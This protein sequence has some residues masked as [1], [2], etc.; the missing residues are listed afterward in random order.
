MPGILSEFLLFQV[1]FSFPSICLLD[2]LEALQNC[3]GLKYLIMIWGY[4]ANWF[5]YS[6]TLTC[7]EKLIVLPVSATH[8]IYIYLIVC[9]YFFLTTVPK[10]LCNNLLCILSKEEMNAV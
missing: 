6:T 2:F 10:I 1:Q 3:V 5:L 8:N 9:F 7:L 4:Y